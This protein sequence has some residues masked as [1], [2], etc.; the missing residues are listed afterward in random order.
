MDKG[1]RRALVPP[2][3][4]RRGIRDGINEAFMTLACAIICYSRLTRVIILLGVLI[5]LLDDGSAAIAE[6]AKAELTAIGGEAVEPLAA[7]VATLDRYGQLCA[8]GRSRG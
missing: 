7:A 3:T 2:T 4:H 1:G 8:I 6:D 5:G